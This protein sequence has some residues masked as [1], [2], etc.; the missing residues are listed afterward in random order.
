MT[1]LLL[2][3]DR[4]SALMRLLADAH[5]LLRD[6]P[7]AARHALLRGLCELT[8]AAGAIWSCGPV[9]VEVG[10]TADLPTRPPSTGDAPSGPDLLARTAPGP[11]P[12][13]YLAFKRGARGF[14]AED[15]ALLGLLSEHAAWWLAPF[16]A[17]PAR[18]TLPPRQ[19]DTLR[20]LLTGLSEKQV[21]DAL[22]LSQHTVHDYV[23]ALYRRMRV[24]SRAELLARC[25]A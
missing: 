23:K 12:R 17:A 19:Q 13:H 16:A 18:P 25:L 8:G 1:D 6:D 3:Y 11:G 4:T 10:G 9:R 22:Q 7:D 20:L 15:A 5:T 2:S 24:S 14:T 21:A